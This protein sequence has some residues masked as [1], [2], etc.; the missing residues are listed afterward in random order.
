M[1]LNLHVKVLNLLST[2]TQRWK[3]STVNYL[4]DTSDFVS[5]DNFDV[6]EVILEQL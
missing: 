6:V 2:I 5:T 4:D 1:F 3:K